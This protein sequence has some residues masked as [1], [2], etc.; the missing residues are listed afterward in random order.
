[1]TKFLK[2]SSKII[3]IKHINII[4][5]KPNK[6]NINV[7]TSDSTGYLISGNG[8]IRSRDILIEVCEVETP[9]DYKTVSDWINKID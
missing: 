3:N 7:M 4:S 9:I 2:L 5:I 8:S 1:M 6:Y